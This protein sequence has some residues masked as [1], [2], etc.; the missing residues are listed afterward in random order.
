MLEFIQKESAQ[1]P[2]SRTAIVVQS[3]LK[4]MIKLNP[5]LN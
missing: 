1:R 3:G 2:K 5:Y 4:Q